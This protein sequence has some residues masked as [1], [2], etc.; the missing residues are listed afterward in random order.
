MNTIK[1]SITMLITAA[2]AIVLSGCAVTG[3]TAHADTPQDPEMAYIQAVRSH[4][5][6]EIDHTSSG[7]L[8]KLGHLYC[9]GFA[10]GFTGNEL[11][12]ISLKIANPLSLAEAQALVDASGTYLCPEYKGRVA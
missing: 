12:K 1:S 7:G 10:K 4:N 9:K 2:A 8:L 11:V 3:L 6:S 5:L